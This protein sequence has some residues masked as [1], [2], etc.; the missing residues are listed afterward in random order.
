M[1]QLLTETGSAEQKSTYQNDILIANKT[2]GSE[3]RN[4]VLSQGTNDYYANQ[5]PPETMGYATDKTP[6]QPLIFV[7]K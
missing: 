7:D 3:E 5:G 1:K 4:R 6:T 2:I